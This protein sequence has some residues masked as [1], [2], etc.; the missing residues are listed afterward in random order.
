MNT[1]Q[2]GSSPEK[3]RDGS[4]GLSRRQVGK[5][6]VAALLAATFE[7]SSSSNAVAAPVTEQGG[8]SVA[9]LAPDIATAFFTS[10]LNANAEL[11]RTHD[12]FAAQGFEF[13][14]SRVQ[15]A[16]CSDTDK[17]GLSHYYMLA[18]APSFRKF[19]GTDLNHTAVSITVV[20]RDHRSIVHAAKALVGHR[21][22]QIEAMSVFEPEGAE[23]VERSLS[24]DLIQGLSVADGAAVLGTPTTMPPVFD[25]P[26]D[27]RPA[28]IAAESF[29]RILNDP[30]SSPL[31]PPGGL[32]QLLS[33]TPLVQKFLVMQ[34]ERYGGL[35]GPGGVRTGT[36]CCCCTCCCCNGC[37]SCCC[38]T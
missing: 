23:F 15:L 11:R 30:F 1:H 22:Y 17:S 31:Y 18:I 13:H 38:C 36:S 25:V 32:E 34:R 14:L 33:D 10:Q 6:S 20:W 21:P 19:E 2:S 29:R 27:G 28:L 24:R 37:C 12:Y 5:L 8:R 35:L 3:S 7:S 4:A 26:L 9:F 16:V